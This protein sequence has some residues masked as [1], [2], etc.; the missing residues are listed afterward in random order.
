MV[1]SA[2]INCVKQYLEELP[3]VGIHASRAVLYGSFAQNRASEWS[4]IDLI[5]IAPEFDGPCDHNLVENMWAARASVDNRIEPI[6]C[7][8]HEW[9]TDQ[10]RPLLTIARRQG[11]VIAANT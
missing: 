1:D 9:K 10:S 7:G 2:I 11:M 3:A 6:P 8:E 5:V 4:D